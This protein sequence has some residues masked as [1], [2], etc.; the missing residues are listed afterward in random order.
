MSITPESILR[1]MLDEEVPVQGDD[2]D[3]FFSDAEI[4]ALLAAAANS[5]PLAAAN[6]WA[7]KAAFFVKHIDHTEA[8]TAQHMTQLHEHARTQS[9]LYIDMYRL[10][11]Q[12]VLSSTPAGFGVVG[13]SI[14]IRED[15][16]EIAVPTPEG[17]SFIFPAP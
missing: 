15:Q 9:R 1:K 16:E 6:G 12:Q 5:L 13:R 10:S 7:Q 8:G 17:Y 11:L 4:A 2:S 14:P 3:T